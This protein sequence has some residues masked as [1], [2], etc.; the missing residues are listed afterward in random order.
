MEQHSIGTQHIDPTCMDT[1][2]EGSYN[3][4]RLVIIELHG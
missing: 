3:M 1:G 4:F 2:R